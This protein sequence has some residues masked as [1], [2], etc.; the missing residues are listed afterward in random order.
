MT[1]TSAVLIAVTQ[2]GFNAKAHCAS[3]NKNES[4]GDDEDLLKGFDAKTQADRKT[5]NCRHHT[6]T[7]FYRTVSRCCKK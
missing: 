2:K 6:Q 1:V 5:K 3:K 4:K 7:I